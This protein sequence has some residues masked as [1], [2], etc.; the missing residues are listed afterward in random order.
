MTRKNVYVVR[1]YHHCVGQINNDDRG[2]EGGGG[3]SP[4]KKKKKPGQTG[5]HGFI[6]K[7]LKDS[8][9]TQE[10]MSCP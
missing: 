1:L 6:N 3:D 10:T 5:K 9:L 4:A 7:T 8:S 2:D